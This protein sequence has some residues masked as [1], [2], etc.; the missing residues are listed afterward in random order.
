MESLLGQGLSI[1]KTQNPIEWEIRPETD[2]RFWVVG[3]HRTLIGGS[4][5]TEFYQFLTLEWAELAK[6]TMAELS[7]VP[8]RELYVVGSGS[9]G[10]YSSA[11]FSMKDLVDSITFTLLFRTWARP[12]VAAL[13]NF[14]ARL[15]WG[16]NAKAT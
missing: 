1:I 3:T 16:E 6:R 14:W 15:M 9:D 5:K 2:G 13:R 7:Y 8:S 10:F 12:R 4:P 11:G